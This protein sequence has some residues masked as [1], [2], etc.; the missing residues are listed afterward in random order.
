[1]RPEAAADRI[2]HRRAHLMKT[3]PGPQVQPQRHSAMLD[4]LY[5]ES[6]L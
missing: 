2:A 3:A 5:T 6:I 4:A 1:M